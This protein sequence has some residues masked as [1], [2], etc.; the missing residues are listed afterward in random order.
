MAKFIQIPTRASFYDGA[1]D[2]VVGWSAAGMGYIIVGESGKLT[3]IDGGNH[4]DAEQIIA[5]LQK[6]S[7]ESVPTVDLW[8][9]THSHLDHYGALRE[10]ATND[11]LYRSVKIKKLLLINKRQVR[12]MRSNFLLSQKCCTY[13]NT[14][15]AVSYKG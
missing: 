7:G 10:I 1:F 4:E 15:V 14:L 2:N 3:V 11:A 13:Y 8:I 5:L 9:I 6:Y 12:F